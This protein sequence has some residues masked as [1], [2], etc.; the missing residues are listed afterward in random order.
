[1]RTSARP[2]ARGRLSRALPLAAAAVSLSL[3]L[4]LAGAAAAAEIKFMVVNDID[5]AS[6]DGPR[7]GFARVAAAIK[8]ERAG[9][10]PVIAVHAGDSLS[11]SVLS[12]IDKGRHIVELI[13]LL[14]LD[15]FVPG[16]HEFDFGKDVFLER[17]AALEARNK[18]AANLRLADGGEIPGFADTARLTFGDVETCIVGLA[19]DHSYEVSSPGDLKIANSV[20]TGL[21]AAK[22]LRGDGC[23]LVVAVAHAGRREDLALMHSGA[24]DLV[25]SGDDH[26]L[27]VNY[28]GRAVLMEGREQGE[29]L[30]VVTLDVEA[31][32]KDGKR[33]VT[34]TPAFKVIDTAAVTPD[35]AVA[36]R[37]TALEAAVSKELDLPIGT[38]ATELDSRRATVRGEEAAIGDLFAD[39]MRDAAGADVAI[40]NGG[41]IRGNRTY[42]AGTAL[43]R[44][45]IV[46]EL[47]FGNVVVSMT[48]SG[49]DL[50]A[51]LE[52]GFSQVEE[53]AGRFP[54]VAGMTVVV[55]LSK[56]AGERV[57]S[58]EIGGKPLD[59]GATYA[60]ATND[61]MARGGDGYVALRK[62]DQVVT[63]RDGKLLAT[64]VA[65]WIAAAGTVSPKPDG[66]I[67]LTGR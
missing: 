27:L 44:R 33:T 25:L 1:M 49:A 35:A 58:V 56:P 11:P 3:A 52:N 53:G 21:A 15:V 47:P 13:G 65:D 36:E 46:T 4:A 7:G 17:M 14:D 62:G 34:W 20:D 5:R 2:P 19:A 41:G 6:A 22:A 8:S 40:T 66:R 26:D 38:T 12:S 24:F 50:R 45:D 31:T 48:L 64:V 42:P 57:T 32:E 51:A 23:D 61:F 28:D 55:D 63:A 29:Y 9:G 30:P 37:I 16:N 39:A 59:P 60:V 18:L 54:Q 10:A 67:T 43:T